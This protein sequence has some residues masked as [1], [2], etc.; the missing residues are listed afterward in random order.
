MAR[1]M[2]SSGVDWIGD[3]PSNWLT[4]RGQTIFNI[5]Q[6]HPFDSALFQD[7]G[8]P[9]IRMSDFDEQKCSRHYS[10]MSGVPTTARVENN[11]ILM[12]LSGSIKTTLWRSEAAYLN[13]RIAALDFKTVPFSLGIY[14]AHLMAS[15]IEKTLAATTIKNVSSA[16][17]RKFAFP[18]ATPAEQ[19]AIASYLDARTKAIDSK[20]QLLEEKSKGLAELRKSVVHQAVTKGLDPNVMMKP[21]GVDW[22]GDVPAHWTTLRGKNFLQHHKELNHAKKHSTIWSLTLDGVRENDPENPIGMVPSDYGTYQLFDSGDFV[23]KLIDVENYR[24][25]RFGIV[26]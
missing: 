6:G 5:R 24:T 2:K 4:R 15:E 12:G 10:D 23:F 22:I 17:M 21:S 13:Q 18:F 1:Q 3:I 14:F 9:V 19:I 11:T 25:S 8:T 7:T 16:Q 26:P 20:I